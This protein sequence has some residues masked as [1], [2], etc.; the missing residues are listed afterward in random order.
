MA[1]NDYKKDQESEHGKAQ[2]ETAQTFIE[3]S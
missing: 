2:T 3:R 1:F